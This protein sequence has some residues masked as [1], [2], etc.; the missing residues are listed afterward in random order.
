MDLTDIYTKYQRG[1]YTYKLEI[2]KKVWDDHV[3]DE[4]LSV[5]SNRERAKAHNEEVDRRR[6]YRSEMQAVLD[7]QLTDDV[8]EYIT[9]NYDLTEAQARKVEHFVYEEYH[10]CM[11][12]YFS[13]IPTYA[14]FAQ[15]VVNAEG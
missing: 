15:D 14:D 8:V 4:N 2:P 12:D 6:K 9:D 5:K 13:N 10:S 11:Y 1:D 7:K 3:F